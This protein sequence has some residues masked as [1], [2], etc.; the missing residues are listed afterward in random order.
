MQRLIQSMPRGTEPLSVQPDFPRYLGQNRAI[1]LIARL[2]NP[3]W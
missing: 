2:G 3:G 1:H